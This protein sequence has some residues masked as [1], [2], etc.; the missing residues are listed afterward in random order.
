M[1]NL[2]ARLTAPLRHLWQCSRCGCWSQNETC[3]FC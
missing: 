1:K 2:L 3:S